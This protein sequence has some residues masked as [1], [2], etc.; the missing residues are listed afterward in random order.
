LKWVY[1]SAVS[2]PPASIGATAPAFSSAAAITKGINSATANSTILCS[3]YTICNSGPSIPAAGVKAR[4]FRV[5][6]CSG[7][8]SVVQYTV[9]SFT[10]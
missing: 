8:G 4:E 2:H 10:A 7:A 1:D 9:S 3:C 6:M 5:F